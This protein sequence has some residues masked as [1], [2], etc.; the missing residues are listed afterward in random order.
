MYVYVD[1]ALRAV[2]VSDKSGETRLPLA[3]FLSQ[4]ALSLA[5]PP[6]HTSFKLASTSSLLEHFR[7]P[8]PYS[9]TTSL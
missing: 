1:R 6:G 2:N 4:V 8:R 5:W 9:S 7:P 3:C